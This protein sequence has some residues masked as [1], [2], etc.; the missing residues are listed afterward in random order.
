MAR[1]SRRP[2]YRERALPSRSPGGGLSE[3]PRTGI[4]VKW[5]L[6]RSHHG[7]KKY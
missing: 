2:V 1:D 6:S 4:I 3:H 7:K 5:D